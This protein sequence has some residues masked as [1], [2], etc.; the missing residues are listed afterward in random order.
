MNEALPIAVDLAD[1][2]LA[3]DVTA[4]VES[5]LGWQV[6]EPGPHLQVRLALSDRVHHEVPT[7]VIVRDDDP[8]L[9]RE[10]LRAG[11]LDVVCWPLDRDRLVALVP[12]A[13]IP[14]P[15]DRVIAVSGAA[16]GVGTTTVALA[17][18][19]QFAWSGA[20]TAVLTDQVGLRMAGP[21]Q[22]GPV[23][24]IDGLSVVAA[25]GTTAG[26]ERPAVLIVDRGIAARG[27]V[28]VARPDAA[29]LNVLRDADDSVVVVT[30]GVGGLRA[31]EISRA[32]QG[33]PHVA[34]DTSFRVARAGLRGR[35]PVSLPGSFLAGVAEVAQ[36]LGVS[37]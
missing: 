10:R 26:G 28:V 31:A 12:T 22:G 21:I 33:R 15:A 14:R 17:L 4:H 27:Q 6:V 35:V 32:V 30:C 16:G 8:E 5:V 25:A 34:L 19:A 7:V 3:A 29:L 37:A 2:E 9:L 1:A 20:R 13:P 11:A 18:G 24:G 36:V 23:A